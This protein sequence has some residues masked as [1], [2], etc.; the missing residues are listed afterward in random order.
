MFLSP[1][2]L[3]VLP[4][5]E[6]LPAATQAAAHWHSSSEQPGRALP[7]AELPDSRE[8]Q[9]SSPHKWPKHMRT[10]TLHL[11]LYLCISLFLLLQQPG[12]VPGGVCR[13]C[14]RGPDQEAP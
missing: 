12:G 4:R 7:P 9:V 2:L 5:V 6:Q 11:T 8:I 10:P 3:L 1:C 14:Q 13:H